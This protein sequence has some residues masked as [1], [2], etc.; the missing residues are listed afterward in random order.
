M[1]GM[2]DNIGGMSSK[3]RARFEELKIKERIG[4]LDD[5]G[6]EELQHLRDRIKGKG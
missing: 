4:N 3:L 5:K 1:A 6:R 2:M